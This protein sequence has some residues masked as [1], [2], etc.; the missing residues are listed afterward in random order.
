MFI[1]KKKSYRVETT[2]NAGNIEYILFWHQQPWRIQRYILYAYK[3]V[4]IFYMHKL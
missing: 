2:S 4:Y 3:Y 1:D